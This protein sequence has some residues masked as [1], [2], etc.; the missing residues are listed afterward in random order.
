M[1][2]SQ[3]NYLKTILSIELGGQQ[4]TVS[5]LANNLEVKPASVTEMIKKLS[6]LDYVNH[7]NYK[8]FKLSGKGKKIA[9]KILRRHRLWETF[10]YKVLEFPWSDVHA[11]AEKFEHLTSELMEKRIDNLLDH[12]DFDPHGHPIPQTDGTW[13]NT[14]ASKDW[15]PLSSLKQGD[16]A[17]VVQVSDDQPDFLEYLDNHNLRLKSKIKV[18]NVLA[19]DQSMEIEYDKKSIFLSNQMAEKI[20]VKKIINK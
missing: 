9:T 2:I 11:E 3:E 8:G 19:F 5:S 1:N 14:N 13:Q 17:D 20:T 16:T 18:C 12:P 10:L 6:A 15:Q 4:A 7:K